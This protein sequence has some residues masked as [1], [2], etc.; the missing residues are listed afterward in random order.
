M[1]GLVSR[2][3]PIQMMQIFEKDPIPLAK[4][5]FGNLKKW[6]PNNRLVKTQILY[7]KDDLTSA[8]P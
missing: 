5:L 1:D 4:G 7:H 3:R 2:F 6:D 8:C